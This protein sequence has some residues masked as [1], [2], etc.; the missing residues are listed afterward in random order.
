MSTSGDFLFAAASQ[1]ALNA[2]H[3]EEVN[4]VLALATKG[5][6]SKDD[7]T[8]GLKGHIDACK[9]DVKAMDAKRAAFISL[10]NA[11]STATSLEVEGLTLLNE[12]AD[13]IA[14]Q[15]EVI[16]KCFA[17][18]K[19]RN[20]QAALSES[21]QKLNELNRGHLRG[22]Y[23]SLQQTTAKQAEEMRK[24]FV[25][26]LGEIKDIETK[27]HNCDS[28]TLIRG[29]LYTSNA[30]SMTNATNA[31]KKKYQKRSVSRVPFP[32]VVPVRSVHSAAHSVARSVVHST[33]YGSSAVVEE[34]TQDDSVSVQG[35]ETEE[36]EEEEEE[37][38]E[39]EETPP[40]KKY[41]MM[42]TISVG[43]PIT[44]YAPTKKVKGKKDLMACFVEEAKYDDGFKMLCAFLTKNGSNPFGV[45]AGGS[46]IGALAF[47]MQFTK[48]NITGANELQHSAV[49]QRFFAERLGN[50]LPYPG[51]NPT[52]E[53]HKQLFLKLV[54]KFKNKMKY[55]LKK[56]DS[57]LRKSL[58]QWKQQQLGK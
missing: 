40:T 14:A 43:T 53:F 33:A 35:A 26:V 50:S 10:F 57:F 45:E 46:E 1:A 24:A 48:T 22:L 27:E 20:V 54:D 29:E 41:R 9:D 36:E 30:S 42:D 2:K 44:T 23:T 49:V 51:G 11:T 39:V 31:T 21:R 7:D 55:E 4:K 34:D 58:L 12:Q 3:T 37:E 47:R 25:V 28:D 15:A 13:I 19:A 5:Y 18:V 8:I 52:K 6:E 32:S 16:E 56:E 17:V 38:K